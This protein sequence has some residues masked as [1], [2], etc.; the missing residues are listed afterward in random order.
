SYPRAEAEYAT[1][2]SSRHFSVSGLSQR[3]DAV[4]SG[5]SMKHTD[6][7][8][9]GM[10]LLA[11]GMLS[12]WA[13]VLVTAAYLVL[14]SPLPKTATHAATIT[15]IRVHDP[16]EVTPA[17]PLS[18]ALSSRAPAGRNLRPADQ[19][20]FSAVSAGRAVR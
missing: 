1:P 11:E 2:S 10:M 18:Q 20:N 8:S 5:D 7:I 4:A 9:G 16:E 15:S 14:R 12:S 13:A 3:L 17:R 19:R 6:L